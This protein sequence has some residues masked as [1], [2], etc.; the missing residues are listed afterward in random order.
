[1]PKVQE[2]RK[3]RSALGSRP[4][5]LIRQRSSKC[6]HRCLKLGFRGPSS[7]EGNSSQER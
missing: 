4:S 1:M 2:G 5:A 7:S 6:T 3:Q